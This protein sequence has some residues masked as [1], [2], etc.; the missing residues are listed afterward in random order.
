[1]V[2]DGISGEYIVP[3]SKITSPSDRAQDVDLQERLWRLSVDILREK[4][5]SLEYKFEV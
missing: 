4:L 3:G 1:M 2:K 5:G